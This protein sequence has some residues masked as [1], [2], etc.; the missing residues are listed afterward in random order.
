MTPIVRIIQ[1]LVH[2]WGDVSRDADGDYV[3]PV[4]FK[5][6]EDAETFKVEMMMVASG[7]VGYEKA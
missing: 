6:K 7:Q 5:C 3:V 4:Y 2:T 1:G